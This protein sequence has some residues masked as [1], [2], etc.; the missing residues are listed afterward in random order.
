MNSYFDLNKYL[1]FIFKFIVIA[2]LLSCKQ[3]IAPISD[4]KVSDKIVFYSNM[5]GTGN[6]FIM[7]SDGKNLKNISRGIGPCTDPNFSSDGKMIVFTC[8][9]NGQDIYIYYV[10]KDTVSL[11]L[12]DNSCPPYPIFFD[13]NKRI[14]F[15]SFHSNYALYSINIDGSDLKLFCDIPKAAE[16]FMKAS[17]DGSKITFTGMHAP[18]EDIY[19]INS[20][21]S[22]LQKLTKPGQRARKSFFS[23]NCNTLFYLKLLS[24]INW[25]IFLI[26]LEDLSTKNLT[27]T[28]NGENYPDIS[29]NGNKLIYISYRNLK[30]DIYLMDLNTGK[31]TNLTNSNEAERDPHFICNDSKIVFESGYQIYIMDI[32]G[33]NKIN[34]TNNSSYNRDPIVFSK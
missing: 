6:L 12:N 27:N 28:N 30:Q 17:P 11:V 4:Q 26:N 20:D 18:Y 5:E 21:G 14:L 33:D 25:D 10:D 24:P 1:I 3:S 19:I 13:N 9:G 8:Y 2:F 15:S 29:K 16:E 23:P 7:D 31:E 34:L 22:N 32:N